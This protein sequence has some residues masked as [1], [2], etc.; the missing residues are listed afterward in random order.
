MSASPAERL[1]LCASVLILLTYTA[2]AAQT[3][4]QQGR[5][6]ELA[7][8]QAEAASGCPLTM[9]FAAV[10]ALRLQPE[11]ADIWV[12]KILAT[13]YDPRNVGIE[14]ILLKK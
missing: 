6:L 7:K 2:K 4:G 13:E 12:P 11:I 3:N 10:P 9:T 14:Q 1:V 5:A 8:S